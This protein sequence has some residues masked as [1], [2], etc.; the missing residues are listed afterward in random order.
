MNRLPKSCLDEVL[1]FAPVF[2]NSRKLRVIDPVLYKKQC[3]RS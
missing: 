2:K 1:I 3:I